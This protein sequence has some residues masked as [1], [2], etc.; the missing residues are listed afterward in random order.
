MYNP[1]RILYLNGGVMDMGGISSYMMNYYRHFDKTKIQID[2]IVHGQGGVF[3]NEIKELGGRVFHVP[4]KRENYL[5]N[6][7][8]IFKIMQKG[9]YHIVHSHMDG[10]NG[11]ILR[12]AK[13]CGVPI[14]ISHSHN[15]SHL[16]NSR[17]KILIHEHARKIIPQYATELW[18]CSNAAGKWLYGNNKFRVVPNAIEVEKYKYDDDFRGVLR[19]KYNLDGKYVIGHIGKFEYQKNH[20][21]LIRMF[22]KIADHNEEMMLMLIG[23]GSLKNEIQNLVSELGLTTQVLFLGKRNDV[24]KLLNIFDVFVLTSRFEGLPVVAVEAQANGLSCVC[25]DTITKEINITG[26]ITF[27]N[28]EDDLELWRESVCKRKSRDLLATDK[29]TKGGYNIAC[30]ALKLQDMY[31]K[32]VRR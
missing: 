31:I 14:R 23:D 19:H 15:T 32:L 8:Q 16:T 29:I 1:I 24:S 21:F 7:K 18:A 27:F 5:E 10:M 25:A 6:K 26:N 28:L 12:M 11:P 22:S 2:F 4:T 9:K 13:K 17:I 20:E 3:D 30:E